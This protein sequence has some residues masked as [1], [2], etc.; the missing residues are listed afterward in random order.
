MTGTGN[1]YSYRKGE[2][3]IPL[4]PHIQAFLE[5][6]GLLYQT[7]SAPREPVIPLAELRVIDEMAK[8]MLAQAN[9]REP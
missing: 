1:P 8:S 3:A 5:Q 4:D 9:E 6:T 7:R 2:E